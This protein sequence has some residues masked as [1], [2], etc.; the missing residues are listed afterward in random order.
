MKG[1]RVGWLED[2]REG[3]GEERGGGRE[4]KGLMANELRTGRSG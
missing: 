2:E 3:K 1:K 4:G